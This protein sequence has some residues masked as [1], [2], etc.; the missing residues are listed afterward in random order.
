MTTNDPNPLI[1]KHWLVNAKHLA[2]PHA[3]A[4]PVSDDINLLV[5]HCISLPEG[6]YDTPYVE[7]LFMG[8]LDTSPATPFN[9]LAGLRVSAHVVIRRHGAVEQYVAFNQRAWHAGK[10]SYC[11]RR[12]C[13]DFSIG[14][15]LEGTDHDSYTEQ[16]YQQLVQ[17]TQ[18]LLACYPNLRRNRIVGHE[19][20][21][22]GRKTD[23]GPGF[24]WHYFQRLLA[25]ATTTP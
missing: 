2:S 25:D 16:Q 17:V 1:D 20:I 12:R 13:N 11:G 3:D 23:P 18:A 8:N 7:Q 24:D 22:R 10:S 21:A 4:R 15:E 19:D 5:I 14:I 9:A 6:H